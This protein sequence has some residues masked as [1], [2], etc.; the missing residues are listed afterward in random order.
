MPELEMIRH[1]TGEKAGLELAGAGGVGHVIAW[2]LACAGG[3]PFGP[4]QTTVVTVVQPPASPC[5]ITGPAGGAWT[6]LLRAPAVPALGLETTQILHFGSDAPPP[7]FLASEAFVIAPQTLAHEPA[8]EWPRMPLSPISFGATSAVS[9]TSRTAGHVLR[10]LVRTTGGSAE[11]VAETLG[12][13]RRSIYNWLKGKPVRS[14]F[15]TRA[16]RLQL[17]LNPLREDWHPQALSGWLQAGAPS[18]AELAAQERWVE[19]EERVRDALG[20]LRPHE[21][22]NE[23]VGIGSSEPWPESA[24]RAALDEFNSPP[25]VP[26]RR[27]TWR[28]RELTG[29]TAEPDE[30]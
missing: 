7:W 27:S 18:P 22:L 9:P 4:S 19:L 15:A 5:D 1:D 2:W 23:P 10:D 29:A 21:A 16:E 8:H 6:N 12:A 20:P 24:I 30:E 3:S 14:E 11:L 26:A 25:P 17:V 13:S 28:P